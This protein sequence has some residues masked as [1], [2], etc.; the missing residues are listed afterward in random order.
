MPTTLILVVV[1]MIVLLGVVLLMALMWVFVAQ[2]RRHISLM[3]LSSIHHD[4]LPLL[5]PL[6]EYAVR[7]VSG[8]LYRRV[9]R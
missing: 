3:T 9:G 4:L 6:I 1:V 7:M 8:L 5:V 2:V